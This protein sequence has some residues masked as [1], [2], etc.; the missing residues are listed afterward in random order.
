MAFTRISHNDQLMTKRTKV[1]I[2]MMNYYMIKEH[3]KYL[4]VIAIANIVV[5]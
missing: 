2:L 3:S 1:G 4:I 5:G